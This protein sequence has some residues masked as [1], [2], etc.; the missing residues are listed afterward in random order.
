MLTNGESVV[1]L[2]EIRSKEVNGTAGGGD[3][4]ATGERLFSAGRGAGAGREGASALGG[5]GGGDGG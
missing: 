4:A 2:G 5:R 1:P 3:A